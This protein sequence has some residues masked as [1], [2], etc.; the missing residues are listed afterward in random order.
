[1]SQFE[2]ADRI[3]LTDEKHVLKHSAAEGN[4][5]AG[6]SAPFA[7]EAVEGGCGSV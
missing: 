5:K 4:M 6:A 3:H 7:F 1:M 2:N